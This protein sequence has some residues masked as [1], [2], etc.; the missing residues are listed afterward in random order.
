MAEVQA[1]IKRLASPA[2]R[3]DAVLIQT[4]MLMASRDFAINRQESVVAG[5]F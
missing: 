5:D 2:G 3:L 4:R 1:L